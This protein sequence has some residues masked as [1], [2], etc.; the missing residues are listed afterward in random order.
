MAPPES[1]DA[2]V[3]KFSLDDCWVDLGRC[4]VQRRG[5]T[6][7]LT[8]KEVQLLT[9]LF[10]RSNQVVPRQEL[11]EHV[12]G[13]RQGV[14]TRTVAV[15][16]R[17]LRRKI[18][19]N[20]SE[21]TSLK[22]AHGIGFV[23]EVSDTPQ[24][25]FENNLPSPTGNFVGR[26][27]EFGALDTA[28]R[29][30]AR[31]VS[32]IGPPGIGKT[33]LARRWAADD[34]H[35]EAVLWCD[36]RLARSEG[37]IVRV[38]GS[39]MGVS[40]ASGLDTR[41]RRALRARCPLLLVF[42]NVE[43]CLEPACAVVDGWLDVPQ[44]RFLATSRQFL[45]HPDER[46]IEVGSLAQEDSEVLFGQ[47]AQWHRRGQQMS[48]ADA[49][50]I[51]AIARQL[52]GIPLAI[53]LAA[54]RVSVLSIAD[55]AAR[56]EHRF[57]LLGRPGGDPRHQTLR[58]AIDASW[59]LLDGDEKTAFAQCAA[60]RG[61]FSID[62]AE[63]VL[64]LEETEALDVMH[65]LRQ[66][67]LVTRQSSGGAEDRFG[68]LSILQE[69]A[70][71]RLDP[72]EPTYRRHA[73]HYLSWAESYRVSPEYATRRMLSEIPNLRAV[74]KRFAVADA[75]LAAKAVVHLTAVSGAASFAANLEATE[76]VLDALPPDR[77]ALRCKLLCGRGF[78]LENLGRLAPAAQSMEAAHALAQDL[79]GD[80]QAFVGQ[81]MASILVSQGRLTEAASFLDSA[82]RYFSTHEGHVRRES[83]CRLLSGN[84]HARMNRL[85]EAE[86]AYR[87]SLRL[88]RPQDHHGRA[89]VLACLG[90][91]LASQERSEE[92]MAAITE[93]LAAFERQGDQL[94]TSI[95][96]CTLAAFLTDA[97]DYDAAQGHLDRAL[98]ESRRAGSLHVQSLATGQLGTLAFLRGD[99]EPASRQY[100]R[101]L[102]L[103]QQ[104]GDGRL[105]VTFQA[106]LAAACCVLARPVAAR[107]AMET[108]RGHAAANGD[109]ALQ[110]LLE[111]VTGFFDLLDPESGDSAGLVRARDR[112]EWARESR[113]GKPGWARRNGS[114]RMAT[115]LLD[116]ERKR[117]R[118]SPSGR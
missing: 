9:Y 76:S 26:G 39:A 22:T 37:D 103:N 1:E 107:G 115:R 40:T 18:E 74:V 52:D 8:P 11:E 96:S 61:G 109:E 79:D 89:A 113:D 30:G 95:V 108:A 17:R 45:G 51:G 4:E 65:S 97:G 88:L 2:S 27:V 101:A 118:R 106:F 70:L 73:D 48:E 99:P 64:A 111:V 92:A 32:L 50:H 49:E 67:S 59:D 38:V 42:D 53:E 80:I 5:Q 63:Q 57:K 15:C 104:V 7:H 78:L 19:R 110:A 114:V 116:R 13:F 6:T 12:W 105:E 47:C 46:V 36:L 91:L 100:R 90:S 35:R 68:M 56:L 85:R 81:G 44:L 77:R 82:L 20:P 72:L 60:F 24:P 14:R 43:P 3:V 29:E 10:Q 25:V 112:V 84:L 102:A 33:T 58:A 23:L 71:E 55:I 69:Y 83:R 66:K 117:A 41:V 86:D 21:P 75:E 87:Q 98:H 16:V 31:L 94:R 93:A 34:T 62:A 28:F 54:G